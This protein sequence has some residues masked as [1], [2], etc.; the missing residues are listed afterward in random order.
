M[1][2][3]ARTARSTSAVAL[4]V[5][6]FVG[7]CP[8][9]IEDPAFFDRHPTC[10]TGIDVEQLLVARCGSSLCHGGEGGGTPQ[11]DLDLTSPGFASNLVGVPSTE[12]AGHLRIDPVH[13]ENSFLLAK[14]EG[15][16][17]GCGD[18][19]P[20]IGDLTRDEILCIRAYVFSLASTPLP[21][22]GADA[23]ADAAVDGGP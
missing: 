8:G 14:I 20:L 11:A 13:P 1:R 23:G 2:P 4:L 9:T 10:P 18:R 7:G 6:L 17:A 21:D 5:G 16:P 19:M 15:P 12:C 3:R 22:A